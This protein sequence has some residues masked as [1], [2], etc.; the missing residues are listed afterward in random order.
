MKE[1]WTDENGVAHRILLW[2]GKYGDN[3]IVL[4]GDEE[5]WLDEEDVLEEDDYEDEPLTEEERWEIEGDKRYHQM[6]DRWI[7]EERYA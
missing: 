6:R 1:Y 2:R 7:E 5:V 4:H 3:Y